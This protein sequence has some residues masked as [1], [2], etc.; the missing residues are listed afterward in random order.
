MRSIR[1][2][3]DLLQDVSQAVEIRLADLKQTGADQR[4]L[5]RE[6]WRRRMIQDTI[7]AVEEAE[8]A[9]S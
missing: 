3:M 8:L 5:E 9:A 1:E 4:R 6:R 2:T 7:K